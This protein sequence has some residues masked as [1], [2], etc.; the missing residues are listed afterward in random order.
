MPEKDKKPIINQFMCNFCTQM[1]FRNLIAGDQDLFA[2]N[3]GVV[4]SKDRKNAFLAPAHD[5][6]YCDTSTYS[7][8]AFFE[9]SNDYFKFMYEHCPNTLDK[10]MSRLKKVFFDEY[11]DFRYD[12]LD[13]IL[14]KC[15][16][17][18]MS[19]SALDYY[20]KNI[21]KNISMLN[22]AYD[23]FMECPGYPIDIKQTVIDYLEDQ[24]MKKD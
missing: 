16:P 8:P 6:E 13:N 24:S 9:A 20:Y 7:M 21:Y 1:L 5:F 18:Y 3:I 19:D 10:F 12:R 23:T 2:Y 15:K 17:A 11:D 22:F 14:C 4:F